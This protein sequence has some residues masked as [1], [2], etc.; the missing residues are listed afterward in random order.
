MEQAQGTSTTCN[1][2]PGCANAKKRNYFIT[3]WNKNYPREL[4]HNATYLITC[5]DMCP[6]TQ[7]WHGHAFIYFK[8]P[9]TLT[10]VKKLFG[11]DCHVEK[12]IRCN[13][14][15][16]KY[17]RGEIRDDEHIKSNICEYGKMPMDNGKHRINEVVEQYDSIIDI[18]KHEPLIYCQYRNGLRDIMRHKKE[19]ERFIKP[20]NV[21]WT[22]GPTGRGKTEEP[23]NAGAKNVSYDNGFFSDWGDHRVIS[24]E[25]MDGQIPYKILLKLTDRYHNYYEVNIKGGYKLVD[26]DTI[27][28]TGSKHPCECYPNQNERDSIQQLLRRITEIRCTDPNYEYHGMDE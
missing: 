1:T 9:T 23:F 25:E 6:E 10:G 17:V 22:Y 26:L 7:K 19:K 24:I 27:Y 20:P 21:I 16:I 5:E 14:D 18:M 13:S 28:I 15:C 2:R 8:N 4:P 3:F 12:Y 11:A